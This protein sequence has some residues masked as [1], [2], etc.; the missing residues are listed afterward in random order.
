RARRGTGPLPRPGTGAGPGGSPCRPLGRV[1]RRC[2]ALRLGAVSGLPVVPGA[3]V[4]AVGHRAEALQRP[5]RA[6]RGDARRRPRVQPG[7][8][9][10][11]DGLHAATRTGGLG[12]TGAHHGCPGQRPLPAVRAG[13]VAGATA[14]H[15]PAVL[16]V[17]LAE[18]E[19]DRTPVAFRA[20]AVLELGLV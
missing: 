15:P 6:E 10:G 8:R 18:P 12:A 14:G 4:R 19:P 2:G 11:P 9:R 1:L 3:A 13:A 7:L 16:A 20:Q 17:V 5:G